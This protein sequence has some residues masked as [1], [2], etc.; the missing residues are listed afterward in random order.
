MTPSNVILRDGSTVS[1]LY[2]DHI[3]NHIIITGIKKTGTWG[4]MM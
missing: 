2:A 1:I 3:Y 4:Y